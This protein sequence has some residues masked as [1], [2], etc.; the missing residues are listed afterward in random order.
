MLEAV[1]STAVLPHWAIEQCACMTALTDTQTVPVPVGKVTSRVLA[2]A[3]MDSK[4]VVLLLA[5]A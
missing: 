3:G 2:A 4:T 1:K 5:T